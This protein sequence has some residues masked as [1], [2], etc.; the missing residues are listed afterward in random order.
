[1]TNLTPTFTREQV[2]KLK[3]ET[4]IRLLSDKPNSEI[5]EVILKHE[6]FDENI[7]NMRPFKRYYT[8]LVNRA[9]LGPYKSGKESAEY[10]AARNLIRKRSLRKAIDYIKNNPD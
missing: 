10:K 7:E 3:Y 8:E 6:K 4:T 5:E 2:F 9:I 1:M